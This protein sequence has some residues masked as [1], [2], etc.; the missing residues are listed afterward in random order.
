MLLLDGD[1]R[2]SVGWLFANKLVLLLL[3]L[4]ASVFSSRP[5]CR[6]LCPLGAFYGLFNRISLI[7]LKFDADA[8]TKCGACHQVCPVEIRAD[9]APNSGACI[10]CLRC[11]GACRFGALGLDVAGYGLRISPPIT[12]DQPTHQEAGL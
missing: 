9:E 8:C 6:T 3:M 2:G 1:L 4:T 7:R 10:R 11:T 5:F 12:A